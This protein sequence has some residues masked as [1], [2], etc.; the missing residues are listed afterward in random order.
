[1]N[2]FENIENLINNSKDLENNVSGKNIKNN[3]DNITQDELELANKLNAVE[4]FTVD[5]IEDDFVV[6]ENRTTREMYDIEKDNLP[7]GI[8]SGDI[9]K[10][11]NGKYFIDELETQEVAKRIEK[12]MDDLWN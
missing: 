3:I 11:I 6:L 9:I 1:M 2:L 4:S 7:E 5:R 12:K 10:K 8:K